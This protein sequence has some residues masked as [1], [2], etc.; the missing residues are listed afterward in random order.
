MTNPL[1]TLS[2]SSYLRSTL[3]L[4][5]A[6]RTCGILCNQFQPHQ[7]PNIEDH[8][9]PLVKHLFSSGSIYKYQHLY[10]QV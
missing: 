2:Y 10:N 5:N 9:Y 6:V 4:D 8:V 7:S 3:L 1:A